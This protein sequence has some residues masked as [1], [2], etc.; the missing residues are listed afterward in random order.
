MEQKL[1]FPKNFLWGASTSSY[2]VE[3]GIE[4]N[5]WAEAARQKKVPAAGKSTDHYNLYEKDFDIVK[6]LNHNAHRF[7]IEWSRV[8][9]EEGKFDDS[10][11]KHYREVV[12]ALRARNLEPLVTLWHFTL[13]I[14]FVNKGGFNNPKAVHFFSRYASFVIS[15]LGD[16]VEYWITIN[17]PI[18]YLSNGYLKDFWP[19]FRRNPFLFFKLFNTLVA[20]HNIIY[21]KIK[22][23]RPD[24][25]IGIAKNN[26]NW[27]ANKNLFNAL[28]SKFMIW[29]W[30][31][32]FL[33]KIEKQQDFI[34]LNYYFY[35][36]F[37]DS[38]NH[39]KSDM[40]WD[41]YPK[42]IY[43]VLLELKRYKK[44]IFITENGIS[45]ATDEKREKFI[46]D[47]L[48]W[49]WQAIND[50]VDVR[51]YMY[52]SLLDNFEWH[53]GFGPRFGLVE[54]DYKTLER[55]IRPSALEFAKICKEN[56]LSL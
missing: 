36:K 50:G 33:K 47:Y 17:E 10:Q 32:R 35:K 45:D 55:K 19:P 1:E 23:L 22:S 2:Q 7:S 3:G 49:T 54:I 16:L 30:N 38:K 44:P 14:W 20:S 56:A 39:E 8:E 11:I 5:D 53:H 42:G 46:K 15:Q 27:Q 9:P 48:Y 52:W 25:K 31:Q 40:D 34:G 26:I 37:G 12:L 18:V 24:I 13:P 21:K 51:G 41:I 29:F 28:F 4:N 6:S 43:N